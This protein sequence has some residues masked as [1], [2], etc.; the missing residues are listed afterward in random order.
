MK[1]FD[2]IK[3][4]NYRTL[5]KHNETFVFL[6]LLGFSLV[7]TII[8]PSFLSIENMFDLAHS[9][10]GMAILAIGVFVVLLSGGDVSFTAVAISAQY[11]AVKTLVTYGIDNLA[12]AFLISCMTGIALGSINA[13]LISIFRLPTLITTLGT[14]SFFHGGLL[15]FVGSFPYYT[16]QIPDCFKTFGLT[17]IFTLVRED[18]TKFGLSV[19][20]LIVLGV[21]LMTWII[22]RYTMLG[23]GIY[24]IGGNS[25][26]G[27]LAGIMAIMHVSMIRYASPTLS[28][29]GEELSVIAAVVLG[30][31]RITGGSGSILGTLLGVALIVAIQKNLVLIGLSSFWHQFFVGLIIIVG[32]SITYYQSLRRSQQRVVYTEEL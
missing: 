18:G 2:S 6:V 21:V 5:L 30:G 22:L 27:F 3:S 31:T 11:I 12:L 23:R 10:A 15:E 13:F 19:Y 4:Y 20:V 7:V 1:L 24:A 28:I 29:V 8:N 14:L 25:Y 26:V 32:V 16:G 17:K 9:S